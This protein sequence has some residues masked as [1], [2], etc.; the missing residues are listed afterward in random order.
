[1]QIKSEVIKVEI[2]AKRI[3]EAM[4]RVGMTTYGTLSEQA[5]LSRQSITAIRQR[6]ACSLSS[7]A[8]LAKAL[9]VELDWLTK[10]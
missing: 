10:E 6:G 2:N 3:E 4:V 9:E 1:M 5:N 7:A 8:K